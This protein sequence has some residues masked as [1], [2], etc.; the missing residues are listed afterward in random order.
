[1]HPNRPLPAT[2]VRRVSLPRQDDAVHPVSA[3]FDPVL[4]LHAWLVQRGY[5]SFVTMEFGE[6]TVEIGEPKLLPV[7]IDGAPAISMQR[8]AHVRGQWHLW[9]TYCRWT[10]TL[11]GTQLAHSESR[12]ITINRALHVLNGQALTGVHVDPM[13]GSSRFAF[14]L[15]STVTT[16]PEPPGTYDDEPVTQWCLYQWRP[17]GQVLEVR[18]DGQY[19]VGGLAQTSAVQR[20]FP[21]AAQGA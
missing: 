8:T 7:H 15:G 2:N 16:R 14:D 13:D 11:D 17:N 10:V 9:I 1:M 19:S 3:A 18:G 20:W 5:G 6:P 21:R 12:G 4:G